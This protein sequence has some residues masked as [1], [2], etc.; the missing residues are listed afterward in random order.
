M[1]EVWEGES[2]IAK[3]C[4]CCRVFYSQV[5][6]MVSEYGQCIAI[7]NHKWNPLQ[8]SHPCIVVIHREDGHLQL[9]LIIFFA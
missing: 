9:L 3:G 1:G 7:S 4:D 8:M 5:K 6:S 2:Q